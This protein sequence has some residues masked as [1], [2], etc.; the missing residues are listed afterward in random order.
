M[1]RINRRAFLQAGA[2]T[3][4]LAAAGCSNT[5]AP[6]YVRSIV[7]PDER[8]QTIAGMKP[9]KRQRPLIA[10]L[11]D[12][13]G[14][15]TTDFILPYSVLTRSGVA[16]VVAVGMREGPI[17]LMPAL[18]IM[19]QMTAAQF[20]ATHPDGPD[21]VIVPAYHDREAAGPIAWMQEKS[22]GGSTII[23]VCA[24]AL[25]LAHAG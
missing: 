24:G 12:N 7:P 13:M 11:G 16:D 3:A 23:G 10:V 19:P 5:S 9:P 6:G 4:I 8:A 20:D 25:T 17:Q 1:T 15:E 2:T 14:S 18:A 22:K 21:Y